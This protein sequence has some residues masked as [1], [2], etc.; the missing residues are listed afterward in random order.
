RY[1]GVR[2]LRRGR[3]RFQSRRLARERAPLRGQESSIQRS[4]RGGGRRRER[5]SPPLPPRPIS[6]TGEP[7]GSDPRPPSHRTS[8]APP[9]PTLTRRTSA[10][11]PIT[12]ATQAS[13]SPIARPCA[14]TIADR[15]GTTS[16]TIIGP[17]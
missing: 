12:Q 2:G 13:S 1:I 5:T 15:R 14:A 3:G 4:F 16:G 7:S 10:S 17:P 8:L 11:P 6:S 9:R